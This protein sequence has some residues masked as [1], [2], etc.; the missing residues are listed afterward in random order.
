MNEVWLPVPDYEGWYEVS[1]HGR[2]RSVQRKV[3]NA[4][5]TFTKKSR[6]L[7]L[8]T[9]KKGYQ[10][11]VLCKESKRLG[12]GVHR[13]V[14][15]AFIPNPLG[16]ETVDHI[17]KDP[18]NNH[19]SNLQWM[20]RKDNQNKDQIGEGHPHSKLTVKQVRAIKQDTR[21]TAMIGAT[22]GVS[23]QTIRDILAGRTWIGV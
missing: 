15:K 8:N 13:L 5:T 7:K 1:N 11:A 23:R 22:Y 21:S 3:T 9:V 12:T 4:V 6:V 2:V 20:T 18:T 17:D 10:I 19:V 14:A 16:L